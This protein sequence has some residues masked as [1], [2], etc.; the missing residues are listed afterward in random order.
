MTYLKNLNCISKSFISSKN[1]SRWNFDRKPIFEVG[2]ESKTTLLTFKFKLITSRQL[3]Q[4]TSILCAICKRMLKLLTICSSISFYITSNHN[5]HAAKFNSSR[6]SLLPY[7]T[8]D[9]FKHASFSPTL[10][11]QKLI[12]SVCI[13]R[14]FAEHDKGSRHL[15]KVLLSS[16][17]RATCI[18]TYQVIYFILSISVPL[19]LVRSSRRMEQKL[20]HVHEAFNLLTS[21]SDCRCCCCWWRFAP[22]FRLI[23]CLKME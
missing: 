20:I 2:Y 21:S 9:D 19:H 3:F 23:S 12:Y 11:M 6:S 22:P 1:R 8:A 18:R 5:L 7:S 14:L 10:S 4:A 13:I 16:V 15:M 17:D